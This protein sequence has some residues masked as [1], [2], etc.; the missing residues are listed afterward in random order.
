MCSISDFWD[1]EWLRIN[2]IS[3]CLPV[4]SPL[5]SNMRTHHPGVDRGHERPRVCVRVHFVRFLSLPPVQLSVVL[6]GR[7]DQRCD[8]SLL[9]AD[10]CGATAQTDQ[11]ECGYGF[12]PPF[13]LSL[14]CRSHRSVCKCL[15]VCTS[16]RSVCLSRVRMC[17]VTGRGLKESILSFPQTDPKSSAD[18]LKGH[19]TAF[20]SVSVTVHESCLWE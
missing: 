18:S 13:S 8:G 17:V 10:E 2:Y 19:H 5:I 20:Y 3:Y 1:P 14:A 4:L 12:L 15:R 9:T 16:L 11:Y 6:S 7:G